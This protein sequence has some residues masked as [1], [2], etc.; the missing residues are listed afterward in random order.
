MPLP[1]LLLAAA[2]A[3]AAAAARADNAQHCPL[4]LMPVVVL[5]QVVAKDNLC[6]DDSAA[7]TS[8]S[9]ILVWDYVC[10]VNNDNQKWALVSLDNGNSLIQA[11][12][13]SNLCMGAQGT[14]Q[15]DSFT[16]MTCDPGSATQGYIMDSTAFSE[17]LGGASRAQVHINHGLTALIWRPPWEPAT[18]PDCLH[19]QQFSTHAAAH[20][21][22]T[23]HRCVRSRPNSPCQRARSPTV[24]PA[25]PGRPPPARPVAMASTSPAGSAQPAPAAT[26]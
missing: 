22:S 20:L 4:T 6:V 16:L 12:T 3:P 1:L 7:T 5:I 24:P 17:S 26:A 19:A 10:S 14:S 25:G 13:K 2:A 18:P 15:S 11:A 23:D 9:G 8:N 21:H